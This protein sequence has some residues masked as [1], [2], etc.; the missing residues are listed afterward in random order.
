[1]FTFKYPTPPPFLVSSFSHL[2]GEGRTPVAFVQRLPPSSAKTTV[3][4]D[5]GSRSPVGT[6]W[7]F[8]HPMNAPL[9]CH[10]PRLSR[11]R[12][13]LS[14]PLPTVAQTYVFFLSPRLS[15]GLIA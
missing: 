7:L 5:F 9:P 4:L 1:M 14:I 15:S 13:D 8:P 12:T 6:K 3:L 10:E 11:V 2:T